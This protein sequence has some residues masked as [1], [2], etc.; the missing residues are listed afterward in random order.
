[1]IDSLY[2][3]LHQTTLSPYL[4]WIVLKF[5]RPQ[6]KTVA[7]L[8]SGSGVEIMREHV[9]EESRVFDL[10]CKYLWTYVYVD[11]NGQILHPR[12]LLTKD[13]YA[14]FRKWSFPSQDILLI[15]APHPS[16][17]VYLSTQRNTRWTARRVKKGPTQ[18]ILVDDN[19]AGGTIFMSKICVMP[20]YNRLPFL[21]VGDYLLINFYRIGRDLRSYHLP[22]PVETRGI[23][24]IRHFTCRDGVVYYWTIGGSLGAMTLTKQSLVHNMYSQ[25]PVLLGQPMRIATIGLCGFNVLDAIYQV[26]QYIVAQPVPT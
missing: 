2:A 12:A 5:C 23:S 26:A 15:N 3:F 24:K 16:Q 8:A 14:L 19:Q 13:V 18:Y 11:K 4:Q 17:C 21:L 9:N 7:I 20:D 22:N 1:M 6:I 25:C 10:Y